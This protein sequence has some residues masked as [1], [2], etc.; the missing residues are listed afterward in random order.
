MYVKAERKREKTSE[1]RLFMHRTS[2]RKVCMEQQGRKFVS[3]Y[4]ENRVKLT[5]FMIVMVKSIVKILRAFYREQD[6]EVDRK[7]DPDVDTQTSWKY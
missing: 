1:L 5:I 7:V 6:K 4:C 2:L 3:S